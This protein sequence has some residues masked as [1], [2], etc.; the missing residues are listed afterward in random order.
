[1]DLV[2]DAGEPSRHVGGIGGKPSRVCLT[3]VLRGQIKDPELALGHSAQS[4]RLPLIEHKS[5]PA[6]PTSVLEE[7]AGDRCPSTSLDPAE[8]MVL[9]PTDYYRET[10]GAT[11]NS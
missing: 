10:V 4:T 5:G 6:L 3:R 9:A 11:V 1:M 2:T 7:P 8:P